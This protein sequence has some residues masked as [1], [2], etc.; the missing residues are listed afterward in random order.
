ACSTFHYALK[1]NGFLFLGSSESAD[2]TPHLFRTI[3]KGARI[4][5]AI[6]HTGDK[7]RML[8]RLLTTPRVR[9]QMRAPFRPPSPIGWNESA[10]HRKALEK[11][12]PPSV[13]VDEDHRVVH[14][15]ENAGRY[16]QPP[17]GPLT[18]DIAELVRHELRFDLRAALYRAFERGESTL[19]LPL[20]VR[21]NG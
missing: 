14:L 7:F 8:P 19:S 15:S 11:F 20:L 18:S 2:S 3:E 10:N 12:A 4:Y 16:L 9:E 21:F 5:Q 17:A 1:P 13:L 6:A